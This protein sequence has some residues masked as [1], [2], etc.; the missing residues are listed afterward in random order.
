[1]IDQWYEQYSAEITRFARS[2]GFSPEDAEDLC[3]QVFL[4]AV[5]CQP[6][7][8]AP[9]AWLHLVAKNRMIDRWRRDRPATSL[10]AWVP[11]DADIEQQALTDDEHAHLRELISQLAPSHR[12]VL[13]LRFVDGLS[14]Q[15]TARALATTIGAVKARQMRARRALRRLTEPPEPEPAPVPAVC[16]PESD[17]MPRLDNRAALLE[18][19]LRLEMEVERLRS[20]K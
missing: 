10:E 11:S 7:D 2:K 17:D 1:M 8:I 14:L 3:A 16:D 20:T 18:R 19:C 12:Q 15:D 4:E 9:R 6:A 5:R 13:M